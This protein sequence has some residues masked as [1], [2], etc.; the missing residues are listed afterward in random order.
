MR[1]PI[2]NLTDLPE[3]DKEPEFWTFIADPN[4]K[5]VANL[6]ILN[7]IRK[8]VPEQL[9]SEA[10]RTQLAKIRAYQELLDLPRA[11]ENKD[12]EEMK[13]TDELPE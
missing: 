8:Y 13:S 1:K 7:E 5:V 9:T 2:Y 6:M 12:F 10:C 3:P 11:L 4:F